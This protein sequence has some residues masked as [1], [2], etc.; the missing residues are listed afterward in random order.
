VSRQKA[1]KILS[2]YGYCDSAASGSEALQAL[3]MA[4]DEGRP[5]DL[6]TMDVIM[7]GMDGIET[8]R[9]I[10]EKEKKLGLDF[11]NGVKVIML[12]AKEGVDSVRTSFWEGCE[13]YVT[14]PF[15]RDKLEQALKQFVF[16][17]AGP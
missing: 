13:A 2:S 5:Y 10:R 11:H 14:K 8:L 15:N 16:E 6:V 1:Q 12:T 4:R 9:R 7:P 17:S 3:D